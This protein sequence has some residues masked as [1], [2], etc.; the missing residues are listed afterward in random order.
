MADDRFSLRIESDLGLELLDTSHAEELFELTER[1]REYLRQWLPWLDSNKYL[2][3]T[4]DFIKYSQMQYNQ[5]ISLQL[6]IRYRGELAGV[7]GFHR[8]DWLN[9]S[10]SIGYWLGESSQGKG[11][12]T[13]ACRCIIDYAFRNFGLNRIEIRC[14]VENSRSRAIPVRLGFKEEGIIRE[15]EW[16]CDHYVDHV[17]Y[18]MLRDEWSS[19]GQ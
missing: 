4:I 19:N 8:F 9:H 13:R 12:V 3:N 10:T 11:L 5:N 7:I 18:G 16:L 6:G 15:A 14:A 2:Q 1:N 17:V